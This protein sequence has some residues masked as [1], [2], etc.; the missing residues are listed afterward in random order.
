MRL[1]LAHPAQHAGPGDH[2]VEHATDGGVEAVGGYEG[3]GGERGDQRDGGLGAD[4]GH[5]E[6][7]EDEPERLGGPDPGGPDPGGVAAVADDAGRLVVPRTCWLADLRNERVR[8]VWLRHFVVQASPSVR[9][10]DQVEVPEA[11]V[12]IGRGGNG[13]RVRT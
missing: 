12:V 11:A 13:T 1:G 9:Q 5:L 2:L 10:V 8:A 3:A 6:F 7:G 4:R